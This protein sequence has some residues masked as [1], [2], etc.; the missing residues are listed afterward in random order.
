MKYSPAVVM[1]TVRGFVVTRER[2]DG[3]KDFNRAGAWMIA[4]SVATAWQ[5]FSSAQAAADSINAEVQS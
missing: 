2:A 5:D 3:V 1:Q 4:A